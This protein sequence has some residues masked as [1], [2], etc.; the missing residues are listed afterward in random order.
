MAQNPGGRPSTS[1]ADG[2]S[3][4]ILTA[5]GV[6]SRHIQ[7]AQG[8]DV[9]K[10]LWHC[11]RPSTLVIFDHAA[12]NGANS[13]GGGQGLWAGVIFPCTANILGVIL[14]LRAPWI[15]GKAG[16]A[17]AFGLVFV[18]CIC[19]FV[20]TLSLSAVATNG[21][22]LG[23]GS[24][25]IISRSLGPALGAGVGLCFYMANSIGAAMYLMGTVEAWEIAMPN[26]QIFEVGN[27]N[28]IRVTA[29]IL[30]AVC[31]VVVGGGIKYV[32]RLGTV[33]LFIVLFV[34][35]CM[36]L[37][38]FIG[39]DH[40]GTQPSSYTVDIVSDSGAESTLTLTWGGLARAAEYFSQNWGPAWDEPQLAY[41]ADTTTYSFISM[42]GLWFPA[43]TGIMAGSNR[44]ADLKNPSRD[45]P[46]GTLCAQ[47]V[48]SFLYLSFIV[49][50]GCV[51]PRASLLN[52]K[53]FA[54]TAAW[55]LKEI[56]IYGVMASTIG[57][58]LTSLVSGTRLLSAIAT[59]KTLPILKVFAVPPGQEPRLALAASGILCACAI[60]IGELNAVAPILT[61]FFL[62]CYTCVNA[63]CTICE[64]VQDP[65]WRPTFRFHHWSVSLL[66]A[67]LC[68]WMMFAMSAIKAMIAIVFCLIV[69]SYSAYNSNAVKWGDGFQGMKFQVARNILMKLHLTA[70]TKNWRPQVLVLTEATI[71]EA[72]E[73]AQGNPRQGAVNQLTIQNPDLLKLVSQL[74]G[75][76]GITILGGICDSRGVAAL[77]EGGN[78]LRAA[79]EDGVDDGRD[80]LKKVLEE[81]GIEGFG[82]LLYTN[83][84]VEGVQCLIQTAGLGAFQPNCVM[85][86]W[87]KDEAWRDTSKVGLVARSKMIRT[88]QT[89]VVFNKVMLMA[90][91]LTWP[92]PEERLVGTIDV[93]W[94]VG[95]GGV[96]LLLP[97][98]LKK[99]KVWHGCKTRLFVVA[100]RVGTDPEQLGQD[101][102][103][104]VKDFRLDVEVFV[105]VLDTGLM[106]GDLSMSFPPTIESRPDPT[107]ASSALASLFPAGLESPP[108]EQAGGE[109]EKPIYSLD[110]LCEVGLQE[111]HA[112]AK[113]PPLAESPFG[114][115]SPVTLNSAGNLFRQNSPLS[116]YG[117]LVRQVSDEKVLKNLLENSFTNHSVDSLRRS[118]QGRAEMTSKKFVSRA[119]QLVSAQPCSADELAVA[120]A[121]GA[122]VAK[123]SQEAD[124][125][126]TNL[127]DMPPD[128]SAFAY[129]EIVDE[130]TKGLKRC[131][132]VRGTAS[133]VITQFT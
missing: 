57:A 96:L 97:F 58:G 26:A 14:F 82:R 87:P 74:K 16:I 27:I 19:T 79:N 17:N 105:Q 98:L 54:S 128:E 76:R 125:V 119:D 55:P 102:K 118:M 126:V 121:L 113:A 3:P 95:D 115:G 5:E 24:Y 65:N 83:N 93:W 68:I 110:E 50:Y 62:M 46:R 120:S 72:E 70:H 30:L 4:K 9:D 12:R 18:C 43:N 59:D 41:P 8:V 77:S 35:L 7:A 99:H 117:G 114:S 25:Y 37:G 51:A 29:L 116:G 38:C 106:A 6:K 91:G 45:I 89:A 71:V 32:V 21:K 40:P 86:S 42:M 132:L 2:D 10:S 64:A 124:L 28:N 63:S 1:R 31:L 69:M 84:F 36:Y 73:H 49:I 60:G 52:D 104:Y 133:E 127:P 88:V 100:D 101:L 75:G 92:N 107:A 15:V 56:V 53:F 80:A 33:F 90:K 78:F 130:M 48:T 122:V 103:T 22:I 109:A 108:K 123:E 44:S 129:F 11:R 131:L 112:K 39:P 20:T 111:A 47:L 61:M 13:S 67:L 66:G 94:I 34:I 81:F 85:L 23:G